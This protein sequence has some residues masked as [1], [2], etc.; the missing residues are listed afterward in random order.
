MSSSMRCVAESRPCHGCQRAREVSLRHDHDHRLWNPGYS[1]WL[2]SGPERQP[3][4]GVL[5]KTGKQEHGVLRFYDF[6]PVDS[7]KVFPIIGNDARA[8]RVL[9]PDGVECIDKIDVLG[10]VEI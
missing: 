5:G 9:Q 7:L 4:P 2:Q 6:K 1:S 10:N 8:P 3:N